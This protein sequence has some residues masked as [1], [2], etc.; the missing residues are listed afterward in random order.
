MKDIEFYKYLNKTLKNFEKEKK[1]IILC[2]EFN[3]NL[4]NIEENEDVNDYLNL[5][6]SSWLTPQILGPT[7]IS[8][9]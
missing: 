4:L 2:G 7:R 1:K 6:L 5:L 8:E 3:L 9:N